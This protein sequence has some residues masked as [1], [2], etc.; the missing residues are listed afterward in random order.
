MG[1]PVTARED[2]AT[3]ITVRIVEGVAEREGVDPLALTPP[4][5]DVIDPEAVA[6]LVS[7]RSGEGTRDDVRLTFTYLGY[8]ITVGGDGVRVSDE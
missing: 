4:L 5:A 2:R 1:V 8:E 6:S 7:E 3:S